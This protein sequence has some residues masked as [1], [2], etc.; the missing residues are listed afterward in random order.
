M[1]IFY[2][3]VLDKFTRLG[4]AHVFLSSLNSRMFITVIALCKFIQFNIDIF[5]YSDSKFPD[6]I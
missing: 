4:K 2:V 6:R 3:H 1:Y 5:Y